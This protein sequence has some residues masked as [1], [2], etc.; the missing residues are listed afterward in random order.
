MNRRGFIGRGLSLGAAAAVAGAVPARASAT[1]PGPSLRSGGRATTPMMITSHTNDT[2]RR[3]AAASWQILSGGGTAMDA[4]ERGANIIELD[5]DETSVGWGGLPNA[6]GVVQLDASVMDGATYNAG[7]VAGIEGIRTPASVARLVMERTDHVMLIGEY[8]QRFAVGF[9]FEVQELMTPKSREIW[10]RWRERLSDTDDWGPPDHLRRPRGGSGGGLDEAE[11]WA[12]LL[13]LPGRD[14]PD[15][16]YVL[17]EALLHRYGTTNVLAV[18]AQGNVSGITT[19]SGLAWKVP[20]RVGDSPII[21]AGLYV[22]NDIGAAAV[23]GRGEDVIKS[24]AGY[25]VVSRMGAGRT[26]QQACEDAVAMIRHKYRNVNPDFIPSE[27]FVAINK[28]GDY[29]CAWMP[30]RDTP[31]RMTVANAEGIQT[32]EGVSVAD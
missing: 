27:K 7:S 11:Q 19:T 1:G 30:F 10:L 4:V 5:P 25:Y 6:D 8:A 31:P 26:P 13:D 12:E 28:D 24:C 17:A 21:G 9:G 15:R 23:T 32:Y 3:A 20:G 14:G 29:G 16:D 18:D 22:D 2:G